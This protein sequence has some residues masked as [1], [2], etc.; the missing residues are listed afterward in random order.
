MDAGDFSI[1]DYQTTNAF[2]REL[3]Q[4]YVFVSGVFIASSARFTGVFWGGSD[5]RELYALEGH[6][7]QNGYEMDRYDWNDETVDFDQ[8]IDWL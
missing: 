2:L 3:V 8:E 6:F 7:N 5:Y 1:D 4:R